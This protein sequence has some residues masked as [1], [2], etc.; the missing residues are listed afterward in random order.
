[1]YHF[2]T[3]TSAII[4]RRRPK[5]WLFKLIQLNARVTISRQISST[6]SSK[7]YY[8]VLGLDQK[9][10]QSEIKDAYYKLSKIYHPDVN[11]SEEAA[12]KFH[13]VSEA[14]EVIGTNESR[15]TYDR[16]KYGQLIKSGK[17]SVR[18]PKVEDG[19]GAYQSTSPSFVETVGPDGKPIDTGDYTQFWQKRS[20]ERTS[21]TPGSSSNNNSSS[22]SVNSSG[23]TESFYESYGGNTSGVYE[24]P[25]Q[26]YYR[27]PEGKKS[28]YVN[29]ENPTKRNLVVE[30]VAIDDQNLSMLL[31]LVFIIACI[32]TGMYHNHS[33]AYIPKGDRLN[34]AQEFRD[35]IDS[36]LSQP[37]VYVK[38]PKHD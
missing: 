1:M 24:Q 2:K 14:Y 8:E 4:I 17:R 10:K 12:E 13:A 32:C 6:S 9:A 37:L 38:P 35:K 23:T 7:D 33:T 34:L 5:D 28:T 27:S 11:K 21:A 16:I 3:C 31:A 20:Y 18:E 25:D 29:P 22:Y 36:K 15:K 26:D 19:Y 30:Q